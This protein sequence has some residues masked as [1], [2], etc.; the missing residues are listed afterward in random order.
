MSFKNLFFPEIKPFPDTKVNKNIKLLR[1]FVGD[2]LIV[3]GLIES[4]YIMRHIWN[5]GIRKLLPGPYKPKTVLLLG[6]A[7]GS[8][9]HLVNNLYPEAEITA[10]E[11]DP[12]MIEIGFTYFNLAKVKNLQ[13]VTC[14]ALDFVDG[15]TNEHYDLVLVDCFVGQEIPKKLESLDFFKKLKDHSGFTLINRLWHGK[16]LPISQSFVN[17]LSTKFHFVS[18]FTGTNLVISLI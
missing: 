6:L 9:A 2:T 5:V 1:Y 10:V 18:V 7:G 3:D 11:I 14:D 4:G 17:S 13:I 8:N 15:L 16:Y 12:L